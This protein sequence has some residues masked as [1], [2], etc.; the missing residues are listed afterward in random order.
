MD[1]NQ[2]FHYQRNIDLRCTSVQERMSTILHQVRGHIRIIKAFG[3]VNS[4]TQGHPQLHSAFE[5]NL[6][7]VRLS[8]NKYIN[9]QVIIFSPQLLLWEM[10]EHQFTDL[11]IGGKAFTPFLFYKYYTV[12]K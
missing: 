10:L 11:K 1:G 4:E 9:T 12:T 3:E 6:G 8:Q 2:K 5:A 7:Y